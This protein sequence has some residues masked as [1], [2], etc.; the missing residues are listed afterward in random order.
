[1][2]KADPIKPVATELRAPRPFTAS[3]KAQGAGSGQ[4][5][6]TSLQGLDRTED[7]PGGSSQEIQ[8]DTVTGGS[9]SAPGQGFGFSG[10]RRY[11][12]AQDK[13][14]FIRDQNLGNQGD[15]K[16]PGWERDVECCAVRQRPQ[17][18][19]DG[20][21]SVPPSEPASAGQKGLALDPP[22]L[23]RSPGIG[24]PGHLLTPT[25]GQAASPARWPV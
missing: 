20:L 16:K 13:R 18:W 7:R 10:H 22:R 14:F 21:G 5:P 12:R 23:A 3:I 9:S 25:P 11:I 4:W 17:A 2:G 8:R 15:R 6:H 1:M 24:S 19:Q